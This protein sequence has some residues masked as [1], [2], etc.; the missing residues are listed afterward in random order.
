MGESMHFTSICPKCGKGQPQRDYTRR[1]LA[2]L[3]NAGYQIEA[4]CECCNEFWR[5]SAQ[6][7]RSIVDALGELIHLHR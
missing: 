3:L 2:N 1:T 6:E 4:H 5:I 7:R